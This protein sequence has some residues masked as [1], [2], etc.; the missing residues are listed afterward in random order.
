MGGGYNGDIDILNSTAF[1]GTSVMEAP[2]QYQS[3]SAKRHKIS[4]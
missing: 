2:I 4:M 1:A 3:R